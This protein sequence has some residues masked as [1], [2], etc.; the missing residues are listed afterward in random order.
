MMLESLILSWAGPDVS[1][2]GSPQTRSV[3]ELSELI[4]FVDVTA[5]RSYISFISN[6][7]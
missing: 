4:F 7:F 2:L 3:D 5:L 6:Y 1:R